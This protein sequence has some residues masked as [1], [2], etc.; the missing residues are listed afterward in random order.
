MKV[1]V[2]G[3]AGYIGSHALA[4]LREA[5]HEAVALDTL[6][7]GNAPAV[8]DSELVIGDVSDVDLVA[9]VLQ[10][11]E[12]DTV[13]HFAAYVE[14]GES[15]QDPMKYYVNNTLGSLQLLR[16]LWACGVR[17]FIFSSTAAV[18]G[19]PESVPIPEDAPTHPINAYGHGKLQTEEICSWMARQT[20]F[21]YAA[22][23]YFNACG[24]HPELEIG[25]AR[26][27]ET[28]LIPLVL[29]VPL[30]Q[31]ERITIFGTD[32]PTPDG[33]CIRDYIHVCDLADA[34][35]AA[36]EHLARGGDSVV[37]NLGTGHGYSVREIIE[38]ARK[39]TGHPIPAE[40]TPRRPGDPPRLV[41]GVE[42]ARTLFGWEPTR[43]D[44]A[45]II[46]TAWDWH[47]EHPDGFRE[48]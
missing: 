11:F 32:Y 31:R 26:A 14:V 22:L 4:A 15:M 5:G 1:L 10:E 25:E 30:G 46:Q 16:T 12:I 42:R 6:E 7:S 36:M 37:C 27:H 40:E 43:S 33:T 41:A 38:T 47:R 8:L 24:A 17:R 13:M 18:Y 23:R 29:E 35:V 45:T 21:R 2:T 19:D 48:E 28:H 44:L 34:H 20:D 3:G 39:V 9:R